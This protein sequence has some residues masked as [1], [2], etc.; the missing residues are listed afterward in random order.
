VLTHSQIRDRRH[1]GVMIS[2]DDLGP[3]IAPSCRCGSAVTGF[4][5]FL[6]RRVGGSRENGRSWQNGQGRGSVR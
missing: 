6:Q 3:G 4:A 2:R 5:W 1:G